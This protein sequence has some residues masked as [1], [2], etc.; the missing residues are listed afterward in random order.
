MDQAMIGFIGAGNMGRSL[1]GGLLKSGWD[2]QRL[3]LADAVPEQRQVVGNLLGLTV[4]ADNNEVADRAD[5]LVLATKP[6]QMRAVCKGLAPAVQ[7]RKPLIVSIAAGVRI[8]NIE[9]WLGGN[10]PIVRVM[11]NT[12]ALVNSGASGLFANPRASDRQRELAES[13]LRTVGVTIWLSSE[14]Q[15]D[16]VTG[17]SGSGPAYFFL[18]MEALEQAAVEQGLDAATARLLAVET[19]FGAAKMALESGTDPAE[20]RRNVTSPGGTT[21]RAIAEFQDG[22]FERL[23]KQAVAAATARSRELADM[24]GG[25]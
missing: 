8:N 3:V 2:R 23:F 19:A 20:L 4:Y 1:A 21:E 5:V 6:Q 13:I 17:V 24:L 12:P 15:L 10:L 22:G 16:A 9:N 11:P 7:R 14:D 18:A 25:E